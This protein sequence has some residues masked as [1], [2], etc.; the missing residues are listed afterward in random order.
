VSTIQ[1][2]RLFTDAAGESRFDEVEVSLMLTDFAPP[3]A[4]G[5]VRPGPRQPIRLLQ[6]PPGWVGDMHPSPGR[7]LGVVLNGSIEVKGAVGE[8]QVV[9][10]EDLRMAITA[11]P[12]SA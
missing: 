11:L 2:A 9:S 7:K 12:N 6:V 3:R 5:P 4:D 8:Q 1:C 10:N